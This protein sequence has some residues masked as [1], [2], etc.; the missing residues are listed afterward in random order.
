MSEAGA[1]WEGL[2]ADAAALPENGSEG[3][4]LHDA[5]AAHVGRSG[6]AVAL[7]GTLLVRDTDL[8]LLRG[9]TARLSVVGTQGAAQLA[10]PLGLAQ[11][12]GLTVA[13]IEVVLRDLDDLPGN[14]RR[15]LAAAEAAKEEGRAPEDVALYL[16]LPGVATTPGWLG[17]AD[18]VAAAGGRLRLP[19][20]APAG[21]SG[22][23]GLTVAGWIDAALDRE[24]P[25]KCSGGLVHAVPP[26]HGTAGGEHGVLELL[27]ATQAAWD[28]GGVTEVAAVLD[29]HYP[30][31]LVALARVA[32]LATARRWLVEVDVVDVDAVA[33]ELQ[34]LGLVD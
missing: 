4:S 8:P 28:G 19:V 34:G 12:L 10:G 15:V 32:D 25:Y 21:H 20:G 26:Q 22:P 7:Q 17:A 14:A 6:T 31:D 33:Q 3:S 29:D 30:N 18:E 24:T 23:D 11:R 13:A 2:L 9:T 5:S 16:E 1:A 27:L